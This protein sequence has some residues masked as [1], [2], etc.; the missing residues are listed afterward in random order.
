MPV[1]TVGSSHIPLEDPMTSDADRTKAMGRPTRAGGLCRVAVAAGILALGVSPRA[2]SPAG[3]GRETRR[4][5][6]APTGKIAAAP[7]EIAA[8]KIGPGTRRMAARLD[9]LIR[10]LDPVDFPFASAQMA[11]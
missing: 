8:P 7:A 5:E 10:N 3:A 6:Q 11:E 9:E 1:D 2:G 4:T